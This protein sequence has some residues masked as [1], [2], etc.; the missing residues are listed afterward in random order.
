MKGTIVQENI[1][2]TEERKC[3][4]KS[5]AKRPSDCCIPSPALPRVWMEAGAAAGP[6]PGPASSLQKRRQQN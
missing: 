1:L 5:R 2:P 4:W 6:T 3:W